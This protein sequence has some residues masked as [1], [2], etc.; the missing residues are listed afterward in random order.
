MSQLHT[1]HGAQNVND[2]K[3]KWGSRASQDGFN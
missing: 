1:G 3:Y 2:Q